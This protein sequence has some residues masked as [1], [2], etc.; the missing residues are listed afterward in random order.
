MSQLCLGLQEDT[1][2]SL[3]CFIF[4][5]RQVWQAITV[6]LYL[7]AFHTQRVKKASRKR[8]YQLQ[9]THSNHNVLGQLNQQI[10]YNAIT[11]LHFGWTI[12]KTLEERHKEKWSNISTYHPDSPFCNDIMETCTSL[13]SYHTR[14]TQKRLAFL[15]S[16]I[17]PSTWHLTEG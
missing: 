14:D 17:T 2:T 4:V 11:L 13:G 8:W 12:C 3:R 16:H 7:T 10:M 6:H 1:Y 15:P 5:S 9:K